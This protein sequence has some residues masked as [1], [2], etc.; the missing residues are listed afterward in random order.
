MRARGN[1]RQSSLFVCTPVQRYAAAVYILY[2]DESGNE[3]DPADRFFVLGGVAVFERQTFYL[4]ESFDQLQQRLIPGSPPL[5]FHASHLR[6]GKAEW[7]RVPEAT[8]SAF[9]HDI[10]Q[11]ITRIGTQRRPGLIALAA[12]IQKSDRLHGEDAVQRATEEICRRFDIFLMRRHTEAQD[13]Q[14]GVIVFSQSRFDAR[15]KLWVRSFR[16]L[17]TRWGVLRNLADI[18]YVAEMAESRPLQ[19]ADFVAHAV[20]RLYEHRDP[21]LVTDLL[22]LFCEKDGTLHG[23]VHVKPPGGRCDCPACASR[24]SPG[25]MGSWV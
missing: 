9:L 4:S 25:S 20:F 17:G 23:L 5:R 1:S 11:L 10:G 8:R 3:K 15:V 6:S 21:T 12:A 7:R 13:T 18:P 14:R 24:R 16:E 22:P 2:I 19:A